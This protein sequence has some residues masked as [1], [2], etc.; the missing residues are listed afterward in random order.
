M[1]KI[2]I[3]TTAAMALFATSCGDKEKAQKLEQDNTALNAELKEAVATQDS[4]LSLVNDIT[5]GMSQIKDLEQILSAPSLNGDMQSRKDQIRND[6][7]AIQQSLQQ[8]RERLAQLE[9]KLKNSNNQNSILSKTISNLK[10]QIAEQ[11]TEIATLHNQLAAANIQISNLNQVVDSLNRGVAVEKEQKEAAQE[12]VANLVNDLNSCYYVI[13]T[14]KELKEHDI[15]EGGGFLRK[16]KIL[17]G[18]FDKN[19]FTRA[20][21]RTLTSIPLHSKKGKILTSQPKDSYE[22]VKD[23]EQDVLRITNADKF[24]S[25]SNLLVIQVD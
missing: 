10:G 16:T 12:E 19:Y 3:L 22:I 24:W 23:G 25:T 15:I 1:K 20:D 21:R 6:M 2:I 5:S 17:Q 4:L 8:R 9:E 13:G 7:I 18:D 14:K 11:E